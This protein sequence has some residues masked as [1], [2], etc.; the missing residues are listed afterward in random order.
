MTIVNGYVTL[1]D[2]DGRLGILDTRDSVLRERAIQSASRAID[3]YC[4]RYF[5]ADGVVSA[6]VFMPGADLRYMD[7]DDISALSGVIIK[8]GVNGVYSTTLA[9]SDYMLE[10]VN[11]IG[12]T[13]E[14]TPYTALRAITGFFPITALGIGNPYTVQVTAKWGWPA[15][16][17]NVS[18]ACLILAADLFHLKDNRWG[19]VGLNDF[20]PVR[21]RGIVG[22]AAAELL[23]TYRRT[24][25]SLGIA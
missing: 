22:A 12:P 9:A 14:Q 19:V 25:Q 17:Q 7:V 8:T 6:R 20:G 4:G 2:L 16:P 10:P 21:V 18:E 5:Y 15:V 3:I 23:H 13:G 24:D 11:P 1:A